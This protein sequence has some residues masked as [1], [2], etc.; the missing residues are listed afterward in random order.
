MLSEIIY[1]VELFKA[2]RWKLLEMSLENV[3]NT[4]GIL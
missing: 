4:C 3:V 1:C 2:I